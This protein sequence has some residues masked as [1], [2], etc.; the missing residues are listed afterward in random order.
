MIS[1][2]PLAMIK[3]V[4]AFGDMT[5]YR[6]VD[7]DRRFGYLVVSTYPEDGGRKFPETLVSTRL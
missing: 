5:S 4:T 2:V 3:N 1:D 6:L 7:K